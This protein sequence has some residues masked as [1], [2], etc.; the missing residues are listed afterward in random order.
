MT[1]IAP[2][3]AV[4]RGLLAG[5]IGTAVMTAWQEFSTK[6]QSSAE[7]GGE[8]ATG[9]G[10]PEPQDPWEQASVP[11]KVGR[12]L[13]EGVFDYHLPPEQAGLLTNAMHWGY[14]TSWGV[15]YA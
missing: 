6:L 13:V 10:A 9:S 5:A 15:L 8:S 7:S 4:A 11:A 14:G 12:K 3:C 2:L 1:R